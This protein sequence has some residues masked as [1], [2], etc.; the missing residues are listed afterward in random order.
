MKK[1]LFVICLILIFSGCG[2]GSSSSDNPLKLKKTK[3]VSP[4]LIEWVRYND[5]LFG[6]FKKSRSKIDGIQAQL[7]SLYEVSRDSGQSMS[8]L[9]KNAQF[10]KLLCEYNSALLIDDKLVDHMLTCFGR[11]EYIIP[12]VEIRTALGKTPQEEQEELREI[13]AESSSIINKGFNSQNS[14]K[15]TLESLKKINYTSKR[16]ALEWQRIHERFEK[17]KQEA[18]KSRDSNLE[19][20]RAFLNSSFEDKNEL[21]NNFNLLQKKFDEVY[22]EICSAEDQLTL[23][24]YVNKCQEVSGFSYQYNK[25]IQNRSTRIQNLKNLDDEVSRNYTRYSSNQGYVRQ[26]NSLKAVSDEQMKEED[27]YVRTV[28]YLLSNNG[29]HLKE[30]EQKLN[31]AALNSADLSKMRKAGEVLN[32]INF[33]SLNRSVEN[34]SN[35]SEEKKLIESIYNRLTR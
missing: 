30:L 14:L 4:K 22:K 11:N 18:L 17:P 13:R 5:N 25:L 28:G 24:E 26:Y 31:R 23:S 1:I 34:L 2:G 27:N 32:N 6:Y 33:S 8:E 15:K 29:A 10:N 21:Y 3:N 9:K 19:I 35:Q 20:A 16:S 12:P 7:M